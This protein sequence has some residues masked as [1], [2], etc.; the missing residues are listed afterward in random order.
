MS[1]YLHNCMCV[2]CVLGAIVKVNEYLPVWLYVYRCTMCMFGAEGSVD[3]YLPTWLYVCCVCAWYWW[4]G[5]W[6]FTCMIVYVPC[7]CLVLMGIRKSSVISWSYRMLGVVQ[8]T[9][10]TEPGYSVRVTSAFKNRVNSYNFRNGKDFF[11]LVGGGT[12]L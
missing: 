11:E 10:R 1:I 12:C 5:E 6:V 4:E 8:W 2:V 3:E 7:A 9:W